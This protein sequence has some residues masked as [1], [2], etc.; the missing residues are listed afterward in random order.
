MMGVVQLPRFEQYWMAP[1]R[2]HLVTS[3]VPTHK[4]FARFCVDVHM[5]DTSVY[6]TA[7]QYVKNKENSFWKLGDLEDQLNGLFRRYRVPHHNGTLDEFTIPFR[8]RHRARQH[9]A[10]KPNPYHLKGFS[11]N[12]ACTGYCLGL[13]MYRGKDEARPKAVSAT[14]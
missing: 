7:E 5:V 2:Q 14:A 9:N 10:K 6:T 3:L 13:Y 11:L 1:T 8:G 4:E 12:E